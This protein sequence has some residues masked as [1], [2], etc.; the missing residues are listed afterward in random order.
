M[1]CGVCRTGKR[2]KS[3]CKPYAELSRL[4]CWFVSL[5]RWRGFE[6][7]F[8]ASKHVSPPL[9]IIVILSRPDHIRRVVGYACAEAVSPLLLPAAGAQGQGQ[10]QGEPQVLRDKSRVH[11][12]T[13]RAQPL[14]KT[15]EPNPQS[16]R[17]PLPKGYPGT[18]MAHAMVLV[19]LGVGCAPAGHSEWWP[20]PV[21]PANAALPSTAESTTSR[22]SRP[23][24]GKGPQ[25]LQAHSHLR[26]PPP[27][28]PLS[29]PPPPAGGGGGEGGRDGG[30][31]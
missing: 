12:T 15:V 23:L 21:P 25:P 27:P 28:L 10:G 6:A 16:P 19:T 7:G 18:G 24:T 30:F 5:Q 14:V 29:P 4:V 1:H 11:Q 22:H 8:R 20:L 31:C 13:S 2:P 3:W 26:Y 17:W 9:D